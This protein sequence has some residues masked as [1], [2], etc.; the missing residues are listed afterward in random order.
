MRRGGA[1]TALGTAIYVL[2]RHRLARVATRR[3]VWFPPGLPRPHAEV[4]ATG[5]LHRRALPSVHPAIACRLALPAR[6]HEPRPPGKLTGA[7][8]SPVP[9]V[10]W[11]VFALGH[12]FSF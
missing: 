2:P 12:F 3:V 5:Q 7:V 8:G 11:P 6:R 10:V 9:V 1:A 4:R